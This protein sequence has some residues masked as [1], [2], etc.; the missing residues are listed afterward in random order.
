MFGLGSNDADDFGSFYRIEV[1]TGVE[2]VD[3]AA[4]RSEWGT[5]FVGDGRDQ[6]VTMFLD[7]LTGFA[8][9]YALAGDDHQTNDSGGSLQHRGPAARCRQRDGKQCNNDAV[10]GHD[11]REPVGSV[12]LVPDSRRRRQQHRAQGKQAVAAK[13]DCVHCRSI[14]I[15][16]IVE[17]QH[18]CHVGGDCE[19][20]ARTDH[21]QASIELQLAPTGED[22]Q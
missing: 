13:P 3:E 11:R 6:I 17:K 18:V 19:C 15:R 14:D 8:D 9:A 4:H 22:H 7:D 5:K 12:H 1:R 10:G 2:D 21:Q 20:H 16:A